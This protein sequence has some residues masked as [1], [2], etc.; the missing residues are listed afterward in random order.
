MDP[1]L[2]S[3]RLT[4]YDYC[5]NSWVPSDRSI[6]VSFY[7]TGKAIPVNI[8]QDEHI[9]LLY[10]YY[11][12]YLFNEPKGIGWL[13]NDGNGQFTV[14]QPIATFSDDYIT[15]GG[16]AGDFDGDDDIDVFGV[17]YYPNSYAVWFEQMGSVEEEEEETEEEETEEEEPTPPV[18][19]PVIRP[20]Q[21]QVVPNPAHLAAQVLLPEVVENG[22]N[23]Q[24]VIYNLYGN[25]VSEIE[26]QAQDFVKDIDLASMHQ[27]LYIITL[28]I[29]GKTIDRC[30]LVVANQ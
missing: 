27:G 10:W 12:Y 8:N 18:V 14:W 13:E 28:N 17:G 2:V 7:E 25:I 26:V 29:G 22:D 16:F 11:T 20:N 3:G 24:L 19:Q 30:K 1:I 6:L 4:P 23:I 21:I 5:T 9:D 15:F